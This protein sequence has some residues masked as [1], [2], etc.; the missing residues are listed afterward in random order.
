LWITGNRSL[1]VNGLEQ[2]LTDPTV[3]TSSLLGSLVSLKRSLTQL[4]FE[5][6]EDRYLTEIAG[7]VTSRSLMQLSEAAVT[8]FLRRA[9]RQETE[10]KGFL[11]AREAL[12]A[13]FSQVNDFS[14]DLLLTRYSKYFLDVRIAP[15]LREF[16]ARQE[17]RSCL[18]LRRRTADRR[19]LL[20]YAEV[21]SVCPKRNG[22]TSIR[23]RKRTSA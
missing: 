4:P 8:V 3:P 19:W 22:R 16:L 23:F 11:A 17:D 5:Q 21:I 18:R 6:L 9:Q 10:S 2:A 14:L 7:T 13:N 12:V 20:R 1:I 15:A